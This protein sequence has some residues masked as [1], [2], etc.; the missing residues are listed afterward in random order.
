MPV[1]RKP[2]SGT[3]LTIVSPSM[4][5]ISRRTP[6]VLGCC[7]PILMVIVSLRCPSPA[8]WLSSIVYVFSISCCILFFLRPRFLILTDMAAALV[9]LASTGC[10]QRLIAH[11]R[12]RIIGH[13]AAPMWFWQIKSCQWIVL[14][15]WVCGPVHRHEN[16]THIGVIC[17]GDAKEIV[18]LSFIPICSWPHS[19]DRWHSR[20]LF[21]TLTNLHF[22]AKHT[23]I[24][25][26]KQVIDDIITGDTLWPIHRCYT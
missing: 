19:N 7:G 20:M 15:Q 24:G 13:L 9:K 1:C 11:A 3:D 22:Q 4:V 21:T 12:V 8:G 14:T 6:C 25:D 26:R 10:A 17:E 23:L 18:Y 5:N 2:I 16:A